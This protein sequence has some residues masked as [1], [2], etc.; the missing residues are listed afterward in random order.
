MKRFFSFF[1]IVACLLSLALFPSCKLLG[2]SSDPSTAGNQATDKIVDAVILDDNGH[3]RAQRVYNVNGD[4]SD[5][6][7]TTYYSLVYTFTPGGRLTVH[8]LS[9]TTPDAEYDYEVR[10]N[11]IIAT[12]P[13]GKKEYFDYCEDVIAVPIALETDT[14]RAFLGCIIGVKD[15]VT[16]SQNGTTTIGYHFELNAKV[17]DLP[18]VFNG[19]DNSKGCYFGIRKNGT[20]DA[21]TNGEYRLKYVN[22]DQINGFDASS[23]GDVIVEVTVGKKV[24][25]AVLRVREV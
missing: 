4:A 11:L 8:D 7:A 18:A 24:Y 23:A 20:F 16:V 17:G 25:K 19:K 2:L 1:L 9:G 5:A 13:T 6:G 3:F 21:K 10:H 12:S 14:S 15:G 22:A